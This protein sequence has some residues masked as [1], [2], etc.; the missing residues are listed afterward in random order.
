VAASAALA[1]SRARLAALD[2]ELSRR[3][4]LPAD[5]PALFARRRALTAQLARGEEA[6]A[7]IEALAA[8]AA[9]LAVDRA[10]IAAKLERLSRRM[11]GQ[12]LPPEEQQ[13]LRRLSQEALSHSLTGR[14]D[15]ANGELN[16]I[17]AIVER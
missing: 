14:Y 2:R 1:L 7:A 8:A 9:A 12:S 11:A 15:Q 5:A 16:A 17:A 6:A 3:G 10:F 4:V 13:R